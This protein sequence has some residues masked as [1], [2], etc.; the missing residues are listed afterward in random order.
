MEKQLDLQIIKE[1]N[2]YKIY[3]V[4]RDDYTP[5]NVGMILFHT[6]EGK[7]Y[8]CSTVKEAESIINKMTMKP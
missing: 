3:K 2:G 6:P 7:E 4:S 5:S 1:I 8:P